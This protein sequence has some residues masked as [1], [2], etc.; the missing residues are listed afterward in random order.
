MPCH[1]DDWLPGFSRA[2]DT[3]PVRAAIE[4]TAPGTTLVDLGYASGYRLFG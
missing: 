2:I 3:A 4:R 1:H